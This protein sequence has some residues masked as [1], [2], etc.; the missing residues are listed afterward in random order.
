MYGTRW[1]TICVSR[2]ICL[3]QAVHAAFGLF[4]EMMAMPTPGNEKGKL[5]GSEAS[6]FFLVHVLHVFAGDGG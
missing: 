5:G 2:I 4:V 1:M 6:F 3:G